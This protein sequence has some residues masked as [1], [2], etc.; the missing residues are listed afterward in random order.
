MKDEGLFSKRKS[1][2]HSY[3]SEVAQTFQSLSEATTIMEENDYLPTLIEVKKCN[4]SPLPLPL[5][6]Y[7]VS[8]D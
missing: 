3:H 2:P 4:N 6:A 1:D 7:F 8:I 5:M